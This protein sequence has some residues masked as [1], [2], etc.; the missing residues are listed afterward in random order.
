V[1]IGASKVAQLD[2]AIG[3]LANRQFSAQECAE[4]DAILHSIK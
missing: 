3:M 2:D 1:L 4:I